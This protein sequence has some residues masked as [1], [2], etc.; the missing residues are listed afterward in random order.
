MRFTWLDAANK[1]YSK[2]AK[3]ILFIQDTENYACV[4]EDQCK[5]TI[6]DHH[7]LEVLPMRPRGSIIDYLAR[8]CKIQTRYRIK[9]QEVN[10]VES[11]LAQIYGSK[12][13]YEH[14]NPVDINY[15]TNEVIVSCLT[16]TIPDI[17]FLL[18]AI[19]WVGYNEPVSNEYIRWMDYVLGLPYMQHIVPPFPWL[20]KSLH[21]LVIPKYNVNDVAKRQ[22]E[23]QP[24]L[25]DPTRCSMLGF[26]TLTFTKNPSALY[27]VY[28]QGLYDVLAK[29]LKE[30]GLKT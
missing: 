6:F 23:I 26:K 24:W 13:Y 16:D 10:E 1:M 19:K 12:F 20:P 22:E 21:F 7:A 18:E 5:L 9:P 15:N 2:D 17:H 25:Y 29:T 11:H 14:T 28:T 4:V 8:W 27:P 30:R 3:Y